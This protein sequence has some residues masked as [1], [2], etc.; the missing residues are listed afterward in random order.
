M[1][2][3]ELIARDADRSN[4]RFVRQR[5]AFEAVDLDDRAGAGHVHQL[6]PQHVGIVGQRLEL[7]AGE[8][9]AEG[10]AARVGGRRLLVLADRD[11]FLVAGDRQHQHLP[12]VAVADPHLGDPPRF[13]ALEIRLNGVAARRQFRDRGHAVRA[14][15]HGL[16]RRRLVGGVNARHRDGGARQHRAGGIHH[17]DLER[18][19]LWRLRT[20]VWD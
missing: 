11:R 7:F 18:A 19:R 14:R 13:E 6:L 10:R 2:G 3:G 1:F 4:L 9:G 16:D 15:L 8:R 20:R 17:R 5:A 12:V